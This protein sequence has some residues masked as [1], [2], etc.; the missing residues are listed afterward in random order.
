LVIL[1]ASFQ[2]RNKKSLQGKSYIL[3]GGNS[4]SATTLLQP[5]S[6]KQDNVTVVGEDLEEGLTAYGLAYSRCKTT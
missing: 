3:I 4:F 1:K 2:A 5:P 6:F